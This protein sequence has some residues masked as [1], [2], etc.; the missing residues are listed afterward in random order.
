MGRN[1]LSMWMQKCRSSVGD[2]HIGMYRK[3]MAAMVD[4]VVMY[5]AEVWECL[6]KLQIVEHL[7]MRGFRMFLGVSRYHPRTVLGMEMRVL[8]LVWEAR[9]R[10][11]L[12]L[13]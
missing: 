5:G 2:L 7:Q 12:I 3:L 4:I 6:G 9:I 8:P 1:A 10:C 13:V 11:M